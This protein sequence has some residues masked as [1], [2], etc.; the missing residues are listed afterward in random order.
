MLVTLISIL[1][2]LTTTEVVAEQTMHH[3]TPAPQ[4]DKDKA[5]AISQAAIGKTLGSYLLQKTNGEYVDL[6]SFKGKPLIVSLIYTSCYHICPTTTQHLNRV[7]KNARQS[8][9]DD[10]FNVVTIGFDV[11][12]DNPPMMQYFAEQQNVDAVQMKQQSNHWLN[13]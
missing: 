7:T 3:H 4:F 2:L 9:G 1:C 13:S 11:R 5:M 12:R 8:L 6:A 10:S